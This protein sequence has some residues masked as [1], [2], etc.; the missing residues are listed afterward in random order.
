MTETA[1]ITVPVLIAVSALPGAVFWRQNAGTFRTMDGRRVVKVSINGVGDIM[2]GYRGR[3]VAL[4][5]KT[6]KGKLRQTQERFRAAWEK[7]GNVYIVARSP[8]EALAA[9][10]AIT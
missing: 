9:L 8:E 6:L 1:D 5:T 3:G 7:S 10:E 2:G 4:E